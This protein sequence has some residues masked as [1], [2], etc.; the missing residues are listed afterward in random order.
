M[1]LNEKNII[2]YENILEINKNLKYSKNE[3]NFSA[4]ISNDNF[5][6]DWWPRSSPNNVS[7]FVYIFKSTFIPQIKDLKINAHK[8][9]P[10]VL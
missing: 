6:H 9:T 2:W 10:C 5:N 3:N 8:C 7:K 1:K 4:N